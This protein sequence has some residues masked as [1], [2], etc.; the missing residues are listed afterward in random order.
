MKKVL[1]V[2]SLMLMGVSGILLAGGNDLGYL[3]MFIGM[4]GLYIVDKKLVIGE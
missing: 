4:I 3:G 2:F 1:G